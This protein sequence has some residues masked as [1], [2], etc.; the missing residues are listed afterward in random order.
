M[1][2]LAMDGTSKIHF[3]MMVLTVNFLLSLQ[4]VYITVNKFLISSLSFRRVVNKLH[5][6]SYNFFHLKKTAWYFGPTPYS[7]ALR[8]WLHH[9]WAV[10][11]RG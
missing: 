10:G 9:V 6:T 11:I 1:T 3:R 4:Y 2:T 7:A 5:L 8:L